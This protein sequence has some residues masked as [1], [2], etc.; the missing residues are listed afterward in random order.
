MDYE[1]ITKK[2]DSYCS[3]H[4]TEKRYKHSVRV[5]EMCV[6]I[7]EKVGFDLE[8]AYLAG[9]SHDICKEIPKPK[10]LK[11]AKKAGYVPS[12]YELQNMSL[13]HGIAGSYFLRKKFKMKDQEVLD[14]VGDHVSGP[15]E[16]NPLAMILYIADKNERGRSH[17]TEDFLNEMFSKN[18]TEMY[19]MA[20]QNTYEYLLKKG[21]KIYEDTYKILDKLGIS[22]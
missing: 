10:M 2:I 8:K 9:I 3:S 15:L 21:F 6:E 13:L 22:R 20:V 14:A 4:L 16:D 1:K 19:K 12:E 5:A 7:A 11:M 17:I 18:L